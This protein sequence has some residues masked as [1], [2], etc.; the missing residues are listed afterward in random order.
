[1]TKCKY[2]GK[3][4]EKNKTPDD[5]LCDP[6]FDL[7]LDDALKVYNMTELERITRMNQYKKEIGLGGKNGK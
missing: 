6:C 7:W 1:M 4:I 3:D 5:E 2:C